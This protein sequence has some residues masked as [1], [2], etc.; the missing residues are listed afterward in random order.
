MSCEACARLAQ[1]KDMHFVAS[2]PDFTYCSL[3]RRVHM[4]G[5]QTFWTL[6]NG[7]EISLV[8]TNAALERERDPVADGLFEM[9]EELADF[10]GVLF[11]DAQI[12]T[13]VVA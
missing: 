6:H 8:K 3:V 5:V 1:M 13:L 10:A 12:E 2:L 11:A 9:D 4:V 7:S